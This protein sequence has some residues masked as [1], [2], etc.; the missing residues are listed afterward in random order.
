MNVKI[1]IKECTINLI[2]I[3]ILNVK[4]VKM[5]CNLYAKIIIT[6]IVEYK[7]LKLVM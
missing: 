5:I 3:M 1:A 4:H 7:Q 2:Q 6:L